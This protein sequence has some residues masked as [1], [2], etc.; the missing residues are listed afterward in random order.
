MFLS[1]TSHLLRQVRL[2][3]PLN[4]KDQVGD[5]WINEGKI[6][7]FAPNLSDIPDNIPIIEAS[8]L[9]VGPGLVDLYS[10]S[11][12]PGYEE[13]E[14][15][16]SLIAAAEAGGFARLNILPTTHPKADNIAT[17]YGLQQLIPLQSPIKVQFWATL[18]QKGKGENMSELGKLVN[19]GISG[20]TDGQPIENLELLRRLL[21]YLKPFNQVIS[22]YPLNPQLR[23]KGVIRDGENAI[24]YGLVGDPAVSETSA[25]TA[26]LEII[27]LTE[28]PVHLMRI[29]TQRS[30][31][32]IE[33]AK[34]SGLPITASVTGLHLLGNN[35]D[36]ATY[37]PHWRLD[38]P[39]GNLSDQNALIDGV[40]RG[41]IDAIAVDHTPYTYEEK[42]VAFADALPGAMGLE[43]MLP[44]LYDKLVTSRKWSPLT[45]FRALSSNPSQCL[46]QKPISCEIGEKAE[47]I[48]FDPQETWTVTKDNIYSLAQNTPWWG[49]SV[50]GKVKT[51]F[52]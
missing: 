39:L 8:S 43:L 38:P 24:L 37:N 27:A 2:I 18:T 49:K 29:S 35:E 19:M 51:R 9:I 13:R 21:E 28:T 22:L 48:V 11:G 23:G 5:L 25:L 26:I 16:N 6:Q 44:L 30:V 42:M 34:H 31:E 50:R 15:L 10:Q 14:T 47:L 46:H 40:N 52:D 1:H 36:V 7:A 17:L 12:E 41:I 33:Q 20:F 4:E 45:L 3:D 32:L